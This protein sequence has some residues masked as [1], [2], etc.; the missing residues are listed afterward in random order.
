MQDLV[1]NADRWAFGAQA[2]ARHGFN[3]EKAV[4]A[5]FPVADTDLA[6]EALHELR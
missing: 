1:I 5:R 6:R 2:P 4:R 3:E